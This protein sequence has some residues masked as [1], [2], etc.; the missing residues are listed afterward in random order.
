MKI[1][2]LLTLCGTVLLF[3]PSLFGQNTGYHLNRDFGSCGSRSFLQSVDNPKEFL[4]LPDNKRLV[5]ADSA[6]AAIV[7]IRLKTNGTRDSTF[8]V[9]GRTLTTLPF[10]F[11]VRTAALSATHVFVVG[12]WTVS[13]TQI[14]AAIV[15]LHLDGRI[16]TSFN[17]TGWVKDNLVP[18]AGRSATFLHLVPMDDGRVVAFGTT[19]IPDFIPWSGQKS[20]ARRYR[21]NGTL[22]PNFHPA[23]AYSITVAP[24][25]GRGNAGFSETNKQ[26]RWTIPYS[27]IDDSNL[28]TILLDSLGELVTSFGTGGVN[29]SP[30]VHPYRP[31]VMKKV[32]DGYVG[33]GS[34]IEAFKARVYKLKA[35]GNVDSTFGIN[36]FR[37]IPNSTIEDESR[38]IIVQNDGKYLIYGSI[39]A[40]GSVLRIFPNGKIDSTLDGDGIA[41][42]KRVTTL[43]HTAF[44]S[45]NLLVYGYIVSEFQPKPY[46]IKLVAKPNDTI[47]NNV[48]GR[49]RAKVNPSCNLINRIWL[50]NGVAIQDILPD[51]VPMFSP[52]VYQ[53]KASV[54]VGLGLEA[55][56]SDSITIYAVNISIPS[57]S[58]NAGLLSVPPQ[59]GVHYQ[60]YLNNAPVAGANANTFTYSGSGTYKV[61]LTIGTCSRISANFTVTENETQR[62]VNADFSVFPNPSSGKFFLRSS[63]EKP[64]ADARIL[65]SLGQEIWRSSISNQEIEIDLGANPSGF[66]ILMYKSISGMTIHKIIKE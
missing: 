42:L 14:M 49:I 30:N 2:F 25:Y 20:F 57:I 19:D 56:L 32:A 15:K 64:A 53:M 17:H 1:N 24:L 52:G 45:E 4:E 10:Q 55:I 35:N 28:A 11:F 46:R 38:G 59:T 65:N 5:V 23:G 7:L 51:S 43:L 13:P 18:T 50:L 6:Q 61:V 66:Y 47:C 44:N 62:A 48:Q 16:D 8:G 26:T 22:D 21:K 12:S 37:D 60:W 54:Q 34:D 40:K 39:N 29:K 31:N 33:A 58:N 9:H 63:A 3:C 41:E 36:G 27:I